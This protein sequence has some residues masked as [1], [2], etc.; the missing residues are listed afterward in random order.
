VSTGPARQIGLGRAAQAEPSA[1]APGVAP[2][3]LCGTAPQGSTLAV[4]GFKPWALVSPTAKTTAGSVRRGLPSGVADVQTHHAR[5][6]GGCLVCEAV[7]ELGTL[8]PARA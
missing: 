7:A 4:R 5:F 2:F 8:C 1:Y 6:G 3:A